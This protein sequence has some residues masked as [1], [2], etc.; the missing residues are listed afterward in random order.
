MTLDD[1]LLV[2]KN[3]QFDVVGKP[4]QQRTKTLDEVDNQWR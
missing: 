2:L 3:N 1:G 4:R